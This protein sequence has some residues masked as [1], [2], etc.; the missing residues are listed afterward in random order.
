M[1]LLPISVLIN[2]CFCFVNCVMCRMGLNSKGQCQI[3]VASTNK[4]TAHHP[5]SVCAIKNNEPENEIAS[6]C[7]F[8]M[9]LNYIGENT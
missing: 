6:S 2:D 9:Q 4:R 7:A 3:E 1:Q 5:H 8:L